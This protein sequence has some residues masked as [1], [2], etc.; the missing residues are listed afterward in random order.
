MHYYITPT[1]ISDTRT[2]TNCLFRWCTKKHFSS[3]QNF[4]LISGH[5]IKSVHVGTNNVKGRNL[6][7]KFSGDNKFVQIM[8][9]A[10]KYINLKFL[11]LRDWHSSYVHISISSRCLIHAARFYLLLQIQSSAF[12]VYFRSGFSFSF[13]LPKKFLGSS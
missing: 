10:L 2:E 8:F 4:V 7:T 1:T 13:Y 3:S 6:I 5:E 9:V 11:T 12:L